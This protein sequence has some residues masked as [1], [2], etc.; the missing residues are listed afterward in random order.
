MKPSISD[1][2]GENIFSIV[3]KCSTILK[4]AGQRDEAKK[5]G[6]RVFASSSYDEAL[7]ICQEYVDFT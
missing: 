7:S 6:E 3:G 5:L 1:P 2:T 4:H